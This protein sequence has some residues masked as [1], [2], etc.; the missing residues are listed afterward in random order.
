MVW[1][2][3]RGGR[4]EKWILEGEERGGWGGECKSQ[5]MYIGK[6][7]KYETQFKGPYVE[8]TMVIAAICISAH[9]RVQTVATKWVSGYFAKYEIGRNKTIFSR[10]FAEFHPYLH[11]LLRHWGWVT[12]TCLAC[13]YWCGGGGD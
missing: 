12:A 11:P 7:E 10:N 5:E 6:R 9:Y 8:S 4:G 2:G 1:G 13:W 3:G